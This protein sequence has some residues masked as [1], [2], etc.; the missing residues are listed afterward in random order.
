MKKLFCI[1]LAIALLLSVTACGEKPAEDTTPAVPSL[2]VGYAAVDI[3]PTESL[4]LDG[5]SGTGT[6][7]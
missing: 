2:S 5:Y 3:S 1:L 7:L 4:P 6:W